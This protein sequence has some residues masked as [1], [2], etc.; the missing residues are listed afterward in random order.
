MNL[1]LLGVFKYTGFFA[2][3]SKRDACK[4]CPKGWRQPAKG[5]GACSICAAGTYHEQT[6]Q[7]QCKTCTI[8]RYEARLGMTTC[9]S[10]P[11]AGCHP[12]SGFKY[13]FLKARF[14]ISGFKRKWLS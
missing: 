10:C 4:A 8:G 5:Q 7:S 6:G 12:L 2:D 1:G 9:K 11:E 3:S 13:N 14:F